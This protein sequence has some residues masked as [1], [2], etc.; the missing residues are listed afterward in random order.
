MNCQES[1]TD[2]ATTTG[3]T[4]RVMPGLQDTGTTQ[5][6]MADGVDRNAQLGC[7]YLGMGKGE[8]QVSDCSCD[9][10]LSYFHIASYNAQFFFKHQAVHNLRLTL[11]TF[12]FSRNINQKPRCFLPDATIRKSRLVLLMSFV[13]KLGSLKRCPDSRMLSQSF[14]PVIAKH[15]L[16]QLST[17]RNN[18]S[19]W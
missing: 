13:E 12:R 17:L 7:S 1:H 14:L 10:F 6:H 3:C 9:Y 19:F 5:P 15:F 18:P 8:G 2:E 16:F 4:D 11:N